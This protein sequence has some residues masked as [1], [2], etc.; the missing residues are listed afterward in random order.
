MS[1]TI[2]PASRIAAVL[3]EGPTTEPITVEDLKKRARHDR[4]DEDGL[5]PGYIAAARQQVEQDTEMALLSQTWRATVP[6]AGTSAPF[7]IELPH[8]PVQTVLTVT[9]HASDGTAT[10]IPPAGYTVLPTALIVRT[11]PAGTGALVIDYV[12]GRAS[13]GA[14][15]PLLVHAVGILA[16]HYLTLGRDLVSAGGLVP[17]PQNYLDAIQPFRPVVVA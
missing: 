12:A 3:V 16:V 10:P 7:V 9:A 4:T 13:A 15:P 1:T 17:V 6:V 11:P 8:P 2:W 5:L 14:L